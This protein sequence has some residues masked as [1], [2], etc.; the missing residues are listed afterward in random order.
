[1]VFATVAE[2]VSDWPPKSI[3]V[4]GVTLTDTGGDK[5]TVAVPDAAVLAWLVAV[6]V[7]V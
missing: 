4:L 2:N 7:T 1:V 6:T 5:L 3:A